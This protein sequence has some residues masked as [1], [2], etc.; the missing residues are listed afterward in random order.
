VSSYDRGVAQTEDDGRRR[1]I[2]RKGLGAI[3]CTLP[4][5]KEFITIL[6]ATERASEHVLSAISRE[7]MFIN[8][9]S[10]REAEETVG[11]YMYKVSREKIYGYVA[12]ANIGVI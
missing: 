1:D 3:L 2:N 9:L 6:C 10:D 7:F 12:S 4:R 5:K 11:F 8:C